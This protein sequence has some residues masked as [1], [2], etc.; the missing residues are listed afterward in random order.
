M[1]ILFKRFHR[2]GVKTF[3]RMFGFCSVEKLSAFQCAGPLT[4]YSNLRGHFWHFLHFFGYR[5]WDVGTG[6][7]KF[8]IKVHFNG[9][10]W[11]KNFDLEIFVGFGWFWP[12]WAKNSIHDFFISNPFISNSTQIWKIIKQ[13][14]CWLR[15]EISNQ[16][17]LC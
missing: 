8:Y 12:I 3:C 4:L 5:S 1:L 17:C 2:C 7:L 11:M 10:S 16:R 14:Q 15:F 6:T 13:L 9:L